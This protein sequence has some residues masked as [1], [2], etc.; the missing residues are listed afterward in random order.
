[1]DEKEAAPAPAS[2]PKTRTYVRRKKKSPA[3]IKSEEDFEE[4]MKEERA[5][6]NLAI[7]ARSPGPE[8]AGP[9]HKSK[10]KSSKKKKSGMAHNVKTMM[11]QQQESMKQ[12]A[13]TMQSY[14]KMMEKM[15][16]EDDEG[17]DDGFE[18]DHNGQDA[19]APADRNEE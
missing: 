8:D 2:E 6:A 10:K 5:K 13:M 17:N 12:W 19:P 11:R 7:G 1:M 16:G 18:D 3:E 15:F 4:L 9:E 14:T